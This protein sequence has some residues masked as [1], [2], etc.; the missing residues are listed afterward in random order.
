MGKIKTF[1]EFKDSVDK[2][3]KNPKNYV[4]ANDFDI[5]E[6]IANKELNVSLL[7]SNR[8]YGAWVTLLNNTLAQK[9]TKPA[10]REFIE[11]IFREIGKHI[12]YEE[13][14]L[15]L[16]YTEGQD[17]YY[18]S[19]ENFIVYLHL[20]QK[21][22]ESDFKSIDARIVYNLS[23]M[24][25]IYAGTMS[26]AG[27]SRFDADNP[28]HQKLAGI[29]MDFPS[30]FKGIKERWE[31]DTASQK[32]LLEKD[33]I[34][35][36]KK[37]GIENIETLK[38]LK[39]GEKVPVEDI[40]K[41]SEHDFNQINPSS[42]FA[43]LNFDELKHIYIKKK[44]YDQRN[45]EQKLSLLLLL[46]KQ[47]AVNEESFEWLGHIF[48]DKWNKYL[49]S[50]DTWAKT[51]TAFYKK[52]SPLGKDIEASLKAAIEQ[53]EKANN[54]LKQARA[55]YQQIYEKG[56]QKQEY[57]DWKN[58]TEELENFFKRC[59]I[60]N[61]RLSKQEKKFYSQYYDFLQNIKNKSNTIHDIKME[62]H[63]WRVFGTSSE[64]KVFDA[65]K[66]TFIK[67]IEL[68]KK[69]IKKWSNQDE[70]ELDK[71]TNKIDKEYEAAKGD[72]ADARMVLYSA[73]KLKEMYDAVCAS[74]QNTDEIHKEKYQKAKAKLSNS[75]IARMKHD[76]T[77]K[78]GDTKR[79]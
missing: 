77:L 75:A 36:L 23:M 22:D 62:G 48:T 32:F 7:R 39:S 30:R 53:E 79:M 33:Q 15:T 60:D 61:D 54:K 3:E 13:G 14:K 38:K 66:A 31:R 69:N 40:I 2:I 59:Y 65:A 55:K 16:D 6:L 17:L 21:M 46:I 5:S 29:A 68:Y 49:G 26:L 1:A 18:H 76:N 72:V 35:V 4:L 8:Y 78:A 67:L 41:L 20:Y 11:N 28:L 42:D 56:I 25:S 12:K 9:K 70:K 74:K 10:K 64:K 24:R 44:C 71:L 47:A 51:Q 63:P 50:F 45:K 57:I 43:K 73:K 19:L 52:F 58:K 27:V 34:N 37:A